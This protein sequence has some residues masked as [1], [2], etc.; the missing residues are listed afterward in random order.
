MINLICRNSFKPSVIIRIVLTIFFTMLAFVPLLHI[1]TGDSDFYK[2]FLWAKA[3]NQGD[4]FSLGGSILS[5][6][7]VPLSQWSFGPGLIFSLGGLF[8][9]QTFGITIFVGWIFAIIFWIS[10]CGILLNVTKNNHSLVLLG[11][12]SSYIGTPLGY[13]SSAYGSESLSYTCLSVMIYWLL[14]RNRFS[15]FDCL[16]VGIWASLL[17]A[18]RS[19]LILYTIPVYLI[20]LYKIRDGYSAENASVTR[21]MLN[22]AASFVPLLLAIVAAST[23]NFWMTGSAFESVYNFGFGDFA[24]VDFSHPEWSAVLVHSWHG[25]FA[26]HPLYLLG[27]AALAEMIRIQQDRSQQVVLVVT[28]CV[29]MLHVYLHAS[30]YCWWLGMGSFGMRGLSICAIILMPIL[31][32][33]LSEREEQGKSNVAVVAV[34][35]VLCLWSFA[36]L[37]QGPTQYYTYGQLFDGVGSAFEIFIGLQFF[38]LP[39]VLFCAGMISTRLHGRLHISL[40]IQDVISLVLLLVLVH[41]QSTIFFYEKGGMLVCSLGSLILM[42]VVI[43]GYHAVVEICQKYSSA[44]K[45][46]FGALSFVCYLTLVCVFTNLTIK[47]HQ[48]LATRSPVPPSYTHIGKVDI[49]EVRASSM[50]YMNVPGFDRKKAWLQSYLEFLD[51]TDNNTVRL[52]RTGH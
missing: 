29:I 42:F 6:Q 19:Q 20:I 28:A 50:E 1:Y 33:I 13:Y 4:L 24:S 34:I 46:L 49:S 25:L 30:W 51:S 11:V 44:F 37:T 48:F 45:R 27:F 52:I 9:D 43:L 7:G 39:A 17:V 3:F 23:A 8:T 31:L 35:M 36:L 32:K 16:V 15:T 10:Y 18:I 22:V 12:S 38:V 47:T 21:S 2:Y 41:Y 14:S 26:Y 40:S 5:P